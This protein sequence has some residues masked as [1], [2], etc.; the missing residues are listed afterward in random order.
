VV[1]ESVVVEVVVASTLDVTTDVVAVLLSSDVLLVK[2]RPGST[3]VVEAEAESELPVVILDIYDVAEDVAAVVTGPLST[4]AVVVSSKLVSELEI[5]DNVLDEAAK[6]EVE[7]S[8]AVVENVDVGSLKLV[9]NVELLTWDGMVEVPPSVL[10]AATVLVLVLGIEGESDVEEG[11]DELDIPPVVPASEDA[12]V[13]AP[14][15]I[16]LVVMPEVEVVSE[17]VVLGALLVVA[18]DVTAEVPVLEPMV[19]ATSP[20][21]DIEVE[22]REVAAFELAALV[23]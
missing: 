10:L 7:V 3:D 13:T 21:V 4:V 9:V 20:V 16:E 15:T 19:L 18:V 14:A 2:L 12:V 22:A 11:L 1:E 6:S 17:V 23:S 8:K 5:V